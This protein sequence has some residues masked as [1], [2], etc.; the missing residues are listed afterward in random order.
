[1][2]INRI[3]AR[4]VWDKDMNMVCDPDANAGQY[5]GQNEDVTVAIIDAMC[6]ETR[7]W[8]VYYHT[9]WSYSSGTHKTYMYYYW[10]N[11]YNSRIENVNWY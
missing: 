10:D 1:M 9:Q 5:T 2:E 11:N 7:T 8:T 4:C 6:L 3:G